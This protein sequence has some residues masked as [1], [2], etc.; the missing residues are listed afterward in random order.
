MDAIID[1][2]YFFGEIFIPAKQQQTELINDFID[3]YQDKYLQEVLGYSFY[4]SFADGMEAETPASKWT[5]IIDGAEYTDANGKTQKWA[6]LANDL[7]V[8]PIANYVYF[9][10]TRNGASTT[11]QSGEKTPGQ[12]GGINTGGY[13]KQVRAWNEM[14]DMNI[15]LYDF[16]TNKKSGD[17]KVYADFETYH[18]FDCEGFVYNELY[19]K[20][21]ML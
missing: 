13:M 9:W 12:A 14:V 11:T 16:L 15:K 6:G 17:T 1:I 18:I 4:K 20:T 7:K 21:S 2:D 5:D 3:K 19:R 8:S 10:F